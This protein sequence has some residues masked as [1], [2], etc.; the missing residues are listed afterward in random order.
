[1]PR[2]SEFLFFN[3]FFTERCTSLLRVPFILSFKGKMTQT[4][5]RAL[6]CYL[7]ITFHVKRC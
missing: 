6:F 5:L 2:T 1:M 7:Y 3:A 4:T